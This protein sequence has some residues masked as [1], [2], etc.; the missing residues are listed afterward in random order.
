MSQ[1]LRR[2]PMEAHALK[3]YEDN[4]LVGANLEM[5]RKELEEVFADFPP[6]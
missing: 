3:G 2:P 5:L 4:L 6:E 1:F